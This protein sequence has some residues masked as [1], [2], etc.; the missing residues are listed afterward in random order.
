MGFLRYLVFA[1]VLHTSY[2]PYWVCSV[3]ANTLC[4]IIGI[5]VQRSTENSYSP[6]HTWIRCTIR[7]W[8]LHEM[9]TSSVAYVM[10]L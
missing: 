8:S 7:V 2:Q 6:N 1:A 5:N 4:M 3:L 10:C 9:N